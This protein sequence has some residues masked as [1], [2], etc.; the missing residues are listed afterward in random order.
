M[1]SKGVEILPTINKSNRL[2]GFRVEFQ[3]LN[4]KATEIHKTMSLSKMGVKIAQIGLNHNPGI[5]QSMDRGIS[6]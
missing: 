6:R 2:Q 1:K 4:L 5:K 3:G